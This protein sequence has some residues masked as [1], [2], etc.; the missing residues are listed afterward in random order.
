[1][2]EMSFL[3]NS[4]CNSQLLLHTHILSTFF[5]CLLHTHNKNTKTKSIIVCQCHLKAYVTCTNCCRRAMAGAEIF[6]L[7]F[8]FLRCEGW[9]ESFCTQLHRSKFVGWFLSRCID[10]ACHLELVYW[11]IESG[12][13]DLVPLNYDIHVMS[14]RPSPVAVHFTCFSPPLSLSPSP[15]IFSWPFPQTDGTVES[16]LLAHVILFPCS[17]FVS[18]RYLFNKWI[19][20]LPVVGPFIFLGV[21]VKNHSERDK[22]RPWQSGKVLVLFFHPGSPRSRF[23][24]L[25][26]RAKR[27]FFTFRI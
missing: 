19:F 14:R 9:V 25:S 4:S 16:A 26:E 8:F 10:P 12:P 18:E 5:Y 3:V 1:M 22:R 23:I 15:A 11:H 24:S 27:K 6:L 2:T 21:D 20:N 7:F 13:L 17:F